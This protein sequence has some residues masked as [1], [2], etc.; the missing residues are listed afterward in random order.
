MGGEPTTSRFITDWIEQAGRLGLDFRFITNGYIMNEE[1]ARRFVAAGLFNIGISLESLDPQI[2]E[3]I[4]PHPNGTAKTVRCIDL[5]LQA[6][7]QQKKHLSLNIKTTLTDLNLESFVPIVRRFGK[8]DGVMCTP[9]MFEPLQDMPPA[10][11]QLLAIKNI[12]RLQR[13]TEEIRV[14]KHEGYMIHVTEQ[15]LCEM[16]KQC[17]E[18]ADLSSTMYDKKLQMDPSEPTCNIATDN[19]WIEHGEV[20]LCPHH[21]PIGNFVTDAATTLKQMWESELARRTRANTR[22]CRRLCTISVSGARPSPTR[23]PP[24]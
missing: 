7:E 12:S 1:M 2:N 6:R 21:P 24:S 5:L 11:K 10:T 20:K 9:Q 16:V 18:N 13:L 15:A 3:T 8:L 17:A 23:S 22:A 19:F 4:R 14:L